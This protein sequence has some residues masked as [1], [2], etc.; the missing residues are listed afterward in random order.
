MGVADGIGVWSNRGINTSFFP[1]TLMYY[2]AHQFSC[3]AGA[4]AETNP[5]MDYKF[6]ASEPFKGQQMTPYECLDL[7]YSRVLQDKHVEGGEHLTQLHK[8][9]AFF[10][11]SMHIAF[12][13]K[14]SLYSQSGLF[15]WP[16]AIS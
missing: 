9:T 6:E 2:A 12:R 3:G 14:Y 1:Q 15:F 8:R 13:F 4:G 10:I 5:A 16:P 11:S 7:A